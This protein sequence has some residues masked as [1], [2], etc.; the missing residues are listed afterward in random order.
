MA[1][2]VT[3][4]K[5]S[6]WDELTGKRPDIFVKGQATEEEQKLVDRM[7][8]IIGEEVLCASPLKDQEENVSCDKFLRFLR[9]YE[10][11]V[12]ASANAYVDMLKFRKDNNID[13][14]RSQI[15]KLGLDVYP[16]R[17]PEYKPLWECIAKG[18]RECYS[19]D[20]FGNLVTVTSIG[21]LD[22]QKVL[23][24]NLGDLYIQYT[25]TLDEWYNLKLFNLS[26]ERGMCIGRHDVINVST[27]G[28][29]QFNSACYKFLGRVFEG[30]G[31]YP[32]S[33]VRITSCGNGWLAMVAWNI[34]RPFIPAR[35]KKKLRAVGVDFLPVLL[36][37]LD[38]DQIPSAWGGI[39]ND[40]DFDRLF[41]KDEYGSTT[42]TV[43]RRDDFRVQL[44]INRP[45]TA[46]E[47]VWKLDSYTIG[48]QAT[49]FSAADQVE[50]EIV[51]LVTVDAS[52]GEHTGEYVAE[53]PGTLILKWDN[54]SSIF[55]S[56]QIVYRV[57]QSTNRD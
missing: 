22:I 32:E 21:D 19:F 15:L 16:N 52:E 30:N 36:E 26:K 8:E 6:D 28:V 48:F 51:P 25:Q 54:T 57:K 7:K 55:R 37:S 38:A 33:C 4:E 9:G 5:P 41:Q 46:I 31:H 35:T 44:N 14:R 42:A 39:K 12:E 27:F 43:S 40:T 23:A 53:V 1:S 34:M 17:W 49:F 45:D 13:E 47:W 10:G 56:K 20:K 11:D 2:L 3:R 24:N 29:F 18:M 50:S